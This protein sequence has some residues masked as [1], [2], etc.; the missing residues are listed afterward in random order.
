MKKSTFGFGFGNRPKAEFY[1]SLLFC[2]GRLWKMQLRSLPGCNMQKTLPEHSVCQS[3]I[4]FSDVKP[5]KHDIAKKVFNCGNTLIKF[6]FC[7]W[8]RRLFSTLLL[9][10]KKLEFFNVKLF[11]TWPH[12]PY[13]RIVLYWV[14]LVQDLVLAWVNLGLCP[15]KRMS[16]RLISPLGCAFS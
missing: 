2:F 11:L 5:L 15:Q 7:F 6:I 4:T 1:H 9:P 14:T 12:S 8:A 13:D 3:N 10:R 16:S